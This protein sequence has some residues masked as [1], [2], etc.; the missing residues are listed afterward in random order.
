M[1]K[2][3]LYILLWFRLWYEW[4]GRC[5]CRC[6]MEETMTNYEAHYQRWFVFLIHLPDAIEDQTMFVFFINLY[7]STWAMLVRDFTTSVLREAM[8]IILKENTFQL[9]NTVFQEI[10][11]HTM[12]DLLHSFQISNT[13]FFP[14]ATITPPY[15]V[16]VSWYILQ[17]VPVS[18]LMNVSNASLMTLYHHSLVHTYPVFVSQFTC[19]IYFDTFL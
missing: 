13:V 18:C 6:V 2:A 11:R 17:S 9:D 5:V 7:T 14:V 8:K 1:P 3:F 16:S 10:P 15:N 4:P 19:G 12:H